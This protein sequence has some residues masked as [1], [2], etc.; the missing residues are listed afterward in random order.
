MDSSPDSGR[1]STH[2]EEEQSAIRLLAQK[3]A[4]SSSSDFMK[5]H[6]AAAL[7]TTRL[8]SKLFS[9]RGPATLNCN[10]ARHLPGAV[11]I[12]V[13]AS[14]TSTELMGYRWPMEMFL[15]ITKVFSS[16]LR[17]MLVLA[18]WW[19]TMVAQSPTAMPRTSALRKVPLLAGWGD[20]IM[21]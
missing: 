15:L 2:P 18:A 5:C 6:T 10:T 4:G 20:G 9:M 7:I 3:A 21:A 17:E 16:A 13:S 14:K 8:R 19:D 11:L 1:T 12:T